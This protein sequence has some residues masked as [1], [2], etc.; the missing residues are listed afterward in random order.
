MFSCDDIS[1]HAGWNEVFHYWDTQLSCSIDIKC[2]SQRKKQGMRGIKHV[3]KA[4]GKQLGLTH[5]D[6]SI[7]VMRLTLISMINLL[8]LDK[9]N[10]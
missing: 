8:H 2:G 4:G 10:T 7:G 5:D 9:K 3:I 1:D 6:E